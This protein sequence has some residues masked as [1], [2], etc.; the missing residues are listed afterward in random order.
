[1]INK[2][3]G[4]FDSTDEDL[5]AEFSKKAAAVISTNPMYYKNEE[6]K[7]SEAAALSDGLASPQVVR[8]FLIFF[9]Y[10]LAVT[11]CQ[12]APPCCT[13]SPL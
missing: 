1:M 3:G 7:S 5:L 10:E 4:A 11:P 9:L 8:R 2:I 12:S 6:K 13:A